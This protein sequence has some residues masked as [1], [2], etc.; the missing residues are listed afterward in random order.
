MNSVD[1]DLDRRI[2][3]SCNRWLGDRV[4]GHGFCSHVLIR[5]RLL[6]WVRLVHCGVYTID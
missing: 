1:S 6:L 4:D 5:E 3:S 2:F